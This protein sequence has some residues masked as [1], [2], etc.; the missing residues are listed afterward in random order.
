MGLFDSFLKSAVTSVADGS[1]DKKLLSALDTIESL[2]NKAEGAVE[3]LADTPQKVI[4]T[5][6]KNSKVIEGRS[7]QIHKH[8][9]QTMDIIRRS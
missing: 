2:A 4:E 9:G 7:K 1:I 5:V 8:A 3:R 6:E